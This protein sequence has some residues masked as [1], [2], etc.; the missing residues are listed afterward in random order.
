M[1]TS[2]GREKT[3]SSCGHQLSVHAKKSEARYKKCKKSFEICQAL[4]HGEGAED[5][6]GW[7]ICLIPCDCGKTYYPDKAK[8][9]RPLERHEYISSHPAYKALELADEY[10]EVTETSYQDEATG[11]SYQLQVFKVVGH[12]FRYK[13]RHGRDRKE[14]MQNLIHE[15]E[16]CNG[17]YH[18]VVRIKDGIDSY[19]TWTSDLPAATEATYR[20]QRTLSEESEDPLQQSDRYLGKQPDTTWNTSIRHQRTLSEES[21]DPLQQTQYQLEQQIANIDISGESSQQ[22]GPIKV[23]VRKVGKGTVECKSKERKGEVFNTREDEWKPQ[24]KGKGF[25]YVGSDGRRFFADEI[26]KKKK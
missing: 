19:W 11:A 10:P 8:A 22:A 2:S 13:D 15:Y 4:Y 12:E 3:C 17:Q 1:S 16:F 14:P 25:L 5:S 21:A 23:S 18:P 6:S 9:A 26:K 20:H 24:G 7:R